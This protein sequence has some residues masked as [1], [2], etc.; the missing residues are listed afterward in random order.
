MIRQDE[1]GTGAANAGEDFHRHALLVDHAGRG[2]RFDHRVLA[3]HVVGADGQ[4]RRLA[5]AAQDVEIR[6]RGLDHQHV[7]ALVLVQRGLAQPLARV[8]RIHL[9]R[10]AIAEL[11]RAVGGVPE[12]PIERRSVLHGIREDGEVFVRA[13]IEGFADRGDAAIHHV[14]GRDDVGSCVGVDQRDA[15]EHLERRVVVDVDHAVAP[16]V[17][18]A[19]VTVV[20]VFVDADVCH[21]DELGRG[22][23]HR[24]DGRRHGPFGIGAGFAAGVLRLGQAEED[25]AAEAAITRLFR[26][27]RGVRDRVLRDAGHRADGT[28]LVDAGVEEQREHQVLRAD[29]RLADERAQRRGAAEATGAVEERHPEGVW[30]AR[31]PRRR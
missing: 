15:G 31:E 27:A 25:D 10:R 1:V 26:D 11:G 7:G 30:L 2:R 16:G 23:F 8:G 14:A 4:R 3:A 22:V 19:A 20:G 18:D 28:G 6:E 5:H 21:H 17:E 29:G 24:A 9:V 13:V 12:R